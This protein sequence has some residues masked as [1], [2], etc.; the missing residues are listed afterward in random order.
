[1]DLPRLV[2]AVFLNDPEF[3]GVVF[4]DFHKG[5]ILLAN[6]EV[7]SKWKNVTFGPGNEGQPDDLIRKADPAKFADKRSKDK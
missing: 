2:G 1:M 7:R 6:P 3:N 5:G 4:D